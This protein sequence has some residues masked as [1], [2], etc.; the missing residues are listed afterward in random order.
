MLARGYPGRPFVIT[1]SAFPQTDR[2][3][4]QLLVGGPVHNYYTQTLIYGSRR[5]AAVNASVIF[6]ADE[7]YIRLGQ[8][9]WGP[10]L[11]LNFRK[12]IPERDYAIILLTSISQYG[13]HQRVVALGG[14]TTY[15]THAAAQF[16]AHQLPQFCDDNGMGQVPNICLLV[17]ARIVNGQPYDLRLIDWIPVN[18]VGTRD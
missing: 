11:D 14:L 10:N 17:H 9:E 13:A 15:G 7:R 8:K 16:L 4:D 1:P 2:R 5:T 12:N 18:E 3:K 6:D